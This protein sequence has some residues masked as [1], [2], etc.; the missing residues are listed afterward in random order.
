MGKL[1]SR[2]VLSSCCNHSGKR[3]SVH[4]EHFGEVRQFL[5]CFLRSAVFRMHRVISVCSDDMRPVCHSG[6]DCS[7]CSQG[8]DALIEGVYS[9]FQAACCGVQ[10]L[11]A[12]YFTGFKIAA[13]KVVFGFF[14]ILPRLK[15]GDSYSVHSRTELE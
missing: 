12:K 11:S 8:F 7:F 15:V 14:D 2:R 1:R 10:D 6:R 5:C 13:L 4:Q 3:E 9:W